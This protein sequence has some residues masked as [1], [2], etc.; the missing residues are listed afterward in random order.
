MWSDQ[1]SAPQDAI[2]QDFFSAPGRIRTCDARFRK[3]AERGSGRF[4]DVRA[5]CGLTRSFAVIGV[6]RRSPEFAP[7]RRAA[8]PRRYHE[9][10][11]RRWSV[12]LDEI[13]SFEGG[14]ATCVLCPRVRFA[15]ADRTPDGVPSLATTCRCVPTDRRLRRQP[16]GLTRCRCVE[17]RSLSPLAEL[18]IDGVEPKRV[19]SSPAASWT[20]KDRPGSS[21]RCRADRHST[22]RLRTP[23]AQRTLPARSA[24]PAYHRDWLRRG[25]TSRPAPRAECFGV[26]AIR[27]LDHPL[28]TVFGIA[29]RRRRRGVPSRPRVFLRSTRICQSS[30]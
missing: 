21:L 5:K 2:Y 18:P 7:F 8:L 16:V 23:H 26:A 22:S 29:L 13:A 20:R 30:A 6:R 27:G 19:V 14:S 9:E 3:G 25:T 12:R 24:K 1:G 11:V 15:S 17:L 10:L 4:A 28:R